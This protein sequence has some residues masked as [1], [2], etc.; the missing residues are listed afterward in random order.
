MS[1][2]NTREAV[3]ALED[4][5]VAI[6]R[7][8]H[9]NAEAS[10]LELKTIEFLKGEFTKLGIEA[11]EVEHGGLIAILEGARPGKSIICRADCDAL[12]MPESDCNLKGP[13]V[14]KSE[15]PNA[16]HACGHDGH[17]AMAMTVAKVLS[18]N[19]DK[20]A[21]RVIF[22]IERGEENGYGGI[23]LLNALRKLGPIDGCYANHLYAELPTGKI[24]IEAGPRMSAPVGATVKLTG[25]GGH[26]SRPDL[27]I[28]PLD[29]FCDIYASCKELLAVKINPFSPVTFVVGAITYGTVGN[30]IPDSLT[31]T[32][33]FRLAD[34]SK[35][36]EAV[37]SGYKKIV[38]TCCE[39]HGVTYEMN[40]RAL[41]MAVI[42][43]PDCSAIA[44]KAVTK[45][46]GPEYIGTHEP[47]MASEDFGLY[48]K[49]WPGV[50]AFVGI[51]NEELGSGAPHHNTNFDID[52][53]A[54]PIGAC[55][56]LQ[57]LLDFLENDKPIRHVTETRS[58][59]EMMNAKI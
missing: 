4:Y 3:Y 20:W 59:E 38:E 46:L 43:N 58:P 47:W 18:E 23:F 30:I 14:C 49:Y 22:V 35:S 27:C 54:L 51:Q 40:L 25:R 24:S 37:I 39:K 8:L 42:N 31:F 11:T 9:I 57:Y 52:E 2:I 26:G 44:E 36:G 7:H 45:A 16:M 50:F 34:F 6:R 55:G 32:G 12:P 33:G 41:D 28:N 13:R 48:L 17:V 1:S 56:T 53:A 10:G 19:K 21:G 15:N 5:T 29:A